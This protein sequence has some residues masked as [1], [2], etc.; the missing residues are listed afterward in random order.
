MTVLSFCFCDY[1]F[2]AA[3]RS[4]EPAECGH[5]VSEGQLAGGAAAVPPVVGR[6]RDG[7]DQAAQSDPTA[8]A[9]PRRL[10]HQEPGASGVKRRASA[11]GVFHHHPCFL[12]VFLFAEQVTGVSEEDG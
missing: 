7:G 9:E 6:P 2:L 11:L 8:A 10:L 5:C 1:Y 12:T 3:E 4:A